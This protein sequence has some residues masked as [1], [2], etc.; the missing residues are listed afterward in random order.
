MLYSNDSFKQNIMFAL[1][2]SSQ[3]QPQPTHK[4]AKESTMYDMVPTPA[5]VLGLKKYG[6][7]VIIIAFIILL[8][9][10]VLTM[11]VAA[12]LS[13]KLYNRTKFNSQPVYCF[14]KIASNLLN[15]FCEVSFNLKS[16]HHRLLNSPINQIIVGFLLKNLCWSLNINWPLFVFLVNLWSKLITFTY[17]KHSAEL[18]SVS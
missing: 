11:R 13:L 10:N 8:K 7:K 14:L 3:E 15:T 17:V 12:A 2:W 18:F 16:I 1:F 6:M 4:P 5:K 9:W